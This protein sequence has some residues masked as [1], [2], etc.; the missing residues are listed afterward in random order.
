MKVRLDPPLTRGIAAAAIGIV[1][2]LTAMAAAPAAAAKRC[3]PPADGSWQR[4]TPAQAGMDADKLEAAIDYATEENGLSVRVF[5]YGCLVGED[6]LAAGNNDTRFESWSLGKSIVS[7]LFGRAMTDGVISPNDRVGSLLP[8]ADAG[9]G[10]VRMVDLLTMSSGVRW[11]GFRD[12][13]IFT[14]TDRVGDWLTLPID[15]PSG[16]WFEYAQSAVAVIPEAIERASGQDAQAY[17]QKGILDKL[18]IEAGSW[19]WQ[20]DQQD[21]VQ[22]FWGA[23][24]RTSDFARLGELMRRGGRW[25]GE[26]LLSKEYVER[27][28]APSRANPCYGWLIWTNN[29][30]PCIG[31][32]ITNRDVVDSYGY[33][34][35]PR[36]MFVYSGLF[37]Q[38]V[39]VF[40][41]QGIVV[42]RNG[43]DSPT[44]LAGATGWQIEFFRRVLLSIVDEPV[45]LPDDPPGEVVESVDG[46][47]QDAVFNPDEYS[48]GAVPEELPPA[49]P[50]RV[51][52][53]VLSAGGHGV[54]GRR[55]F[56]RVRCPAPQ[57]G[58]VQDCEGKLW[59][60]G[61]EKAGKSYAIE[62]GESERIAFKLD[63]S[64]L[65]RLE[66]NGKVTLRVKARNR[67]SLG[68]SSLARDLLFRDR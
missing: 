53:P 67:A 54:K 49:G 21:N 59:E 1:L 20:R 39:A 15:H 33:P 13:N 5:R 61:D 34:D 23:R 48:Q 50:P 47:F 63:R 65:R 57:P 66:R 36:D 64:T 17:L 19:E 24:M 9:H 35:T 14:Q 8:E 6:D 26:R 58:A 44:T 46:G 4:A 43:Q 38:I 11:N 7:L 12:Y 40:P 22:G 16:T 45:K 37:G 28:L 62:G 52:A 30:K 18:G 55:A 56:I 29:A 3:R 25:R 42:A 60:R 32:R 41:S 2:A 27:A 68:G 31:P 51:R 10:R